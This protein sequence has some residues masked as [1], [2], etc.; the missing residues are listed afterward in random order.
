MIS[1]RIVFATR[2]HWLALF[3]NL[4]WC[5]VLGLL[6]HWWWQAFSIDRYVNPENIAEAGNF[7]AVYFLAVVFLGIWSAWLWSS[8]GIYLTDHRL[9][10]RHGGSG[11]YINYDDISQVKSIYRGKFFHFLNLGD[12]V[13]SKS[14][15]HLKLRFLHYPD[16]L[17]KLLN[18]K[19][20][21]PL[22]MQNVSKESN[23]EISIKKQNVVTKEN[24]IQQKVEQKIQAGSIEGEM[25][26]GVAIYL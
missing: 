1:E 4:F 10:I 8:S 13:V 19:I 7:L 23:K 22:Q 21:R 20:G 17:E 14:N 18:K 12:L 16:Q 26:D 2:P 25:T 3:S 5:I 9:I 15:E 6:P 11:S 24:K